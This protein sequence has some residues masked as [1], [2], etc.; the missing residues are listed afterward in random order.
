[1]ADSY[2]TDFDWFAGWLGVV[3]HRHRHR[4]CQGGGARSFDKIATGVRIHGSSRFNGKHTVVLP[5]CF[6][7]LNES[8]SPKAI[9]GDPI[10]RTI[11]F[12]IWY[13]YCTAPTS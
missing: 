2:L 6:P 13:A 3:G 8:R 10:Q 11:A 12:S 7:R 4:D 1:M 5:C 9:V